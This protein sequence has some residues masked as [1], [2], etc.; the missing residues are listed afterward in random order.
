MCG[1]GSTSRVRIVRHKATRQLL[2]LK[3]VDL[4]TSAERVQPIIAELRA[5][6]ECNSPS[7][8][9]FH[10]AFYSNSCASIVMEYMD[11]VCR[12]VERE[13]FCVYDDALLG[14]TQGFGNAVIKQLDT[15]IH[16]LGNCQTG[17]NA[18]T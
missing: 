11:S 8:V 13:P 1:V 6:H 3:Q 15:R 4:D 2:A 12:F 5:L 17:T 16:Y 9:S 18:T 14:L 7:I 10:G